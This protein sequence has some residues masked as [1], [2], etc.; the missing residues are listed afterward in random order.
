MSNVQERGGTYY[1]TA[2]GSNTLLQLTPDPTT[3]YHVSVSHQGGSVG[4][5]QIYNNGTSDAGAGTPTFTV[6][7]QAGTGAAGTPDFEATRDITYGP[8]GRVMDAGLSVLFAAGATGTVAHGV[9]AIVD[10]TYR[11]TMS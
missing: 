11:G 5:L 7:V 3:L 9:N 8:Y 6:A 1:Y 10:I 2:A 4:Y